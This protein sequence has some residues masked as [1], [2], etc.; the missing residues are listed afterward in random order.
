MALSFSEAIKRDINRLE[1][2]KEQV[3]RA[4]K[5]KPTKVGKPP[6]Y[7]TMY[8]LRNKRLAI[9]EAALRL[10][11][12]IITYK[13]ITTG[14][15]KSYVVAPYSYRYRKLR[16]GVK[17]LLYA[18]DMEDKHIKGFVLSNIRKV[19]LTD[20]KFRPKWPVELA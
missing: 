8:A 4:P 12:I 7:G 2:I 19:A 14:E 9:R 5:R 10:V 15:T 6:A 16:V 3:K 13:K 20:R 1:F 18:Y 11:Q 17:K